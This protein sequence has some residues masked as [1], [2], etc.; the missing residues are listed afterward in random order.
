MKVKKAQAPHQ[1]KPKKKLIFFLFE[2]FQNLQKKLY[3]FQIYMKD[4]E[5]SE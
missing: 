4:P 3:I 1:N 2:I 5:S